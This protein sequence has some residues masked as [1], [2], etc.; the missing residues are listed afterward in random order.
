[1]LFCRALPICSLK[2][3]SV[4]PCAMKTWIY[5][6]TLLMSPKL[7]IQFCKHSYTPFITE[8]IPSGIRDNIDQIFPLWMSNIH[9]QCSKLPAI[10]EE[11]FN[12]QKKWKKSLHLCFFLTLLQRR[13]SLTYS[14]LIDRQSYHCVNYQEI[15]GSWRE[16]DLI[17]LGY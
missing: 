7:N 8:M 2:T 6:W 9:W 10:D 12:S 15:A 1:M 11:M 17:I 5:F 13:L 3:C 16:I 4:V 14:I